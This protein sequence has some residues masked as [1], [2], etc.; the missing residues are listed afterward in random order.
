MLG[1]LLTWLGKI[2]LDAVEESALLAARLAPDMFPLST[3][4]S[5]ACVQAQEGMSR[6]RQEPLPLSMAVLLNEGRNAVIK[7]LP[8]TNGC[9]LYA[10]AC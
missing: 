7:C 3:Q 4:I 8:M 6:L 2:D 10:I 5:F 9:G 1:A